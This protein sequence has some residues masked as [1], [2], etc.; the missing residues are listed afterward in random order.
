MHIYVYVRENVVRKTSRERSSGLTTY[1]Y[2]FFS[3][4]TYTHDDQRLINVSNIL[5]ATGMEEASEG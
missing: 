4:P 2:V 5:H 1:I 3:P